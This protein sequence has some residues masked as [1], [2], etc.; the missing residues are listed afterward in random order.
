LNQE[1]PLIIFEELIQPFSIKY[2]TILCILFLC[3]RLLLGPPCARLLTLS[4]SLEMNHVG[5]LSIILKRR[6]F[7]L[8]KQQPQKKLTTTKTKST[9]LHK[10]ID[11]DFNED[12]IQDYADHL[13]N[14]TGPSQVTS[15]FER[16]CPFGYVGRS[17]LF[18]C[19]LC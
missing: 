5:K 9:N 7:R 12:A 19:L 14:V 6:R 15:G 1:I 17:I 10:L 13:K 18:E 4:L 8:G 2:L 11:K 16:S 3:P